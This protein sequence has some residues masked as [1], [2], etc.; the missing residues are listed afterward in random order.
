MN[1][2]DD[3]IR[4]RAYAL[5]ERDGRPDGQHETH[6]KQALAELGLLDPAEAMG[7]KP[8]GAQKQQNSAARSSSDGSST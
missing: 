5:W 1:E 6:W 3:A 2:S 7:V 8:N 4:L